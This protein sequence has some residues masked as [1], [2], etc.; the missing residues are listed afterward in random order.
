MQKLYFT[1]TCGVKRS[2]KNLIFDSFLGS[3]C[4]IWL[5]F[6]L[7]FSNNDSYKVL[8]FFCKNSILRV[9]TGSKGHI[10]ITFLQ[11]LGLALSNLANFFLKLSNNDSYKVLKFIC[12][13]LFFRVPVGSKGHIKITFLVRF[14]D[15][16][17]FVDYLILQITD[18]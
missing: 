16:T 7:K 12:K 10:K 18:V 1:G 8:I 4:P 5:I 13:Y 6:G 3:A 15:F 2:H 14:S 11:F 9:L 17:V